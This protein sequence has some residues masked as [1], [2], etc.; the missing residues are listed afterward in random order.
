MK[1]TKKTLYKLIEEQI[2]DNKKLAQVVGMLI[3][4]D[5]DEAERA[6]ELLYSL[7]IA[8]EGTSNQNVPTLVLE[9]DDDE[10]YEYVM[11][12]TQIK[13]KQLQPHERPMVFSRYASFD[14]K[15]DN[16]NRTNFTFYHDKKTLVIREDS[17]KDI[18][19]DATTT[20]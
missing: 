12:Q 15:V 13:Q 14:I 16:Q 19:G 20:I 7:G 2:G 8:D 3:T 4:A 5:F 11:K 1:L 17:T 10:M 18:I 6:A 9:F